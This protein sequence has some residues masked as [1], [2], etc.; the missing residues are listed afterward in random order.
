MLVGAANS[1]P[2]PKLALSFDK[3]E[4]AKEE[5]NYGVSD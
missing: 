2:C 3:E 1:F 5:E 4:D